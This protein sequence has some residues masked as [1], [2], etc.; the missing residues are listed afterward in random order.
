MSCFNAKA[1]QTDPEGMAFLRAVFGSAS[2]PD[3]PGPAALSDSARRR[4]A[5]KRQKTSEP[6]CGRAPVS[7]S[8]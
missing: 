4:I 1:L 6:R 7:A 5:A 8:V 3:Q 2:A